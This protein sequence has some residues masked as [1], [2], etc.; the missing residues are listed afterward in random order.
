M[1]YVVLAR[2]K[3]KQHMEK[4]NTDTGSEQ[5]NSLM[6]GSGS[7]FVIHIPYFCLGY[8]LNPMAGSTC[9]PE[10]KAQVLALVAGFCHFSYVGNKTVRHFN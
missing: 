9:C 7:N 1:K 4:R 6:T 3:T 8:K 10:R 2:V 5:M